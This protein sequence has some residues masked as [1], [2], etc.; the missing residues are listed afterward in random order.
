MRTSEER[1][2]ELHRR[3]D[4][5]RR[6]KARRRYRLACASAVAACLAAV[7]LVAVA[8]SR[9]PVQAPAAVSGGIAASLLADHA[10]LGV[11]L[12]ALVAFCLG[13]TVTLLCVRL[14]RNM[15]KE[16]KRDD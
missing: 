7:L 14:R 4:L 12:V 2:S 5:R 10:A 6:A 3:M 8:V 1:V 13:V 11:V 16:E 15:E 9:V